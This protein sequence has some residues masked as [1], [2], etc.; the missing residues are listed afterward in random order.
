VRRKKTLLGIIAIGALLL[1][2]LALLKQTQPAYGGKSLSEWLQVYE[3]RPD[4]DHLKA[5]EAI[6]G[7][8]TNGIPLLLRWLSGMPTSWKFDMLM[9]SFRTPEPIRS[10]LRKPE[11]NAEE[12]RRKAVIG[13][14]VLGTNA[15]PYLLSTLTNQSNPPKVRAQAPIAIACMG[16]NASM[17]DAALMNY[18]NDQPQVA[19]A[20]AYA[21]GRVTKRPELAVPAITSLLTNT[22][23]EV[24]WMAIR[25]LCALGTNASAAVSVLERAVSDPEKGV[26]S[27]A[28]YAL[29]KIAPERFPS[30]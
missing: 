7:I 22:D 29:R 20:C 15:L 14:E 19:G 11:E 18:L 12:T 1:L 4:L 5:A 9:F 6:R 21:L 23:R 3:Y 13:F 10:W 30:P 16:T 2:A 25:G 26:R 24:R 28:A 27:M 8:G 17:A